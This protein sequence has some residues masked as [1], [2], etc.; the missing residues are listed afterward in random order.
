M[1]EINE[2]EEPAK[3]ETLSKS[4]LSDLLCDFET[5]KSTI[6]SFCNMGDNPHFY[7][8]AEYCIN[9]INKAETFIKSDRKCYADL[10]NSP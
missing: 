4:D 1:A 8:M 10:T 3:A 6:V 2:T 5:L 7:E 9:E